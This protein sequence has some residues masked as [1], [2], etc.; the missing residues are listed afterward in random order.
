MLCIYPKSLLNHSYF[1]KGLLNR[2]NAQK[3]EPK[4]ALLLFDTKEAV[5]TSKDVTDPRQQSLLEPGY[6]TATIVINK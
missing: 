3:S 4:I 1:M 2:R 6:V 5:S